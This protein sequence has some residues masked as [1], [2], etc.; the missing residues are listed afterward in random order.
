MSFNTISQLHLPTF[1]FNLR[2]IQKR[3]CQYSILKHL[4]MI[5]NLQYKISIH[6]LN[7]PSSLYRF[8]K[9]LRP[10][11]FQQLLTLLLFLPFQQKILLVLKNLIPGHNKGLLQCTLLNMPVSTPQNPLNL[12]PLTALPH[13]PVNSRTTP[14]NL[15]G[16]HLIT[17]STNNL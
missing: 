16:K 14:P 10:V 4:N 12:I 7:L 11:H 1:K 8:L 2:S 13:P 15:P 9:S 5:E 3:N 6:L 17:T